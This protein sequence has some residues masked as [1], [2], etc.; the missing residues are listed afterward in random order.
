MKKILLLGG[1]AQQVVAIETAKRLGYYTVVCDYLSDNP[2][3]FVADRFYL[4]STTDKDAVLRVAEE[5]NVNGVIAYASDPAAP[6]A[7]YVAEKLGLPTN[8][9]KSVDILCNKDK[10]RTF[11][12]DN[13]FDCP[14]AKGYSSAESA[15]QDK[16]S[17][18]YPIIMKPVDSSGSKGVTILQ[19]S[20]GFEN[21]V[22]FAFSFSHSK[23]IIIEK[24]IVQKHKYNIGGDIF[25]DN[26]KVIIWGLMNCFREHSPNP[27]VPGGEIF[28]VLLSDSDLEKAKAVLQNLVTK[29]NIQSGSMN[30]E[31]MIDNDDKVYLIDIGPRAGGNMIPIQLSAIFGVDIVEMSVLAAMGE[32]LNINP[33]IEIPY[34]SHYVL[35]SDADGIYQDIVFSDEIEKNIF[36]KELYKKEGDSVECF[37]N[38]AKALGIIFLKFSSA[39][40]MYDKMNHMNDYVKV[41]LK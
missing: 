7:A 33:H 13:G 27:L 5:E 26:G 12:S 14:F 8:P 35:H 38:A 23:R 2:G 17:F 18:D 24:F 19:S 11:L 31:L 3:Q 36:R 9:Y 32:K 15:I 39:D 30:V 1:S 4:V 25:I 10:F 6:T 16:D 22:E 21:A 29:L 37:D 28:P 34:C 41:V 40:E 20:N